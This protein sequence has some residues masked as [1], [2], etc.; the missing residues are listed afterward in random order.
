MLGVCTRKQ[1]L[2]MIIEFASNGSLKDFL[3]SSK[4]T[5]AGVVEL[6][7]HELARMCADVANGMAF[8]SAKG[9]VHRDLAARFV[10]FLALIIRDALFFSHSW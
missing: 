9:F 7:P 2:M 10:A 5:E 6:L 1:P 3:Q 4:P 8:L